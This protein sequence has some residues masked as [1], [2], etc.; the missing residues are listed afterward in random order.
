MSAETQHIILFIYLY[1][2]TIYKV[3]LKQLKNIV[4]W[5]ICPVETGRQKMPVFVKWHFFFTNILFML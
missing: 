5:T 3:K 4:K 2:K 1:T